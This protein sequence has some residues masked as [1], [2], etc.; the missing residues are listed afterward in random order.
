[1]CPSRLRT[2]IFDEALERFIGNLKVGNTVFKKKQFRN[3]AIG[4][5]GYVWIIMSGWILAVRGN[6]QGR[7][8]GIG[9]YGPGDILGIR[10]LGGNSRDLVCY[11]VSDCVLKCVTTQVFKRSMNDDASLCRYMLD[12]SCRRYA[13]LLDELEASTF[14]SVKDRIKAFQNIISEK[15]PGEVNV[16][17][18]EQVVAWAIGAHP[19]SVCRA[20][21]HE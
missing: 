20:L 4:E 14:L 1:M 13:D 17:L 15:V 18:P 12:Y 11:V 7:I 6:L 21:K 9:I 8:K 2:T 3:L 5:N 16:I 10:G 19:V